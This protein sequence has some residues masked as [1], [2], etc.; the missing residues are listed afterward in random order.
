MLKALLL[1]CTYRYP[2]LRENNIS[3]W[4]ETTVTGHLLSSQVACLNHLF[5]IK[6][7]ENTVLSVADVITGEIFSKVL[8]INC[9]GDRQYV[10]F[11]VVSKADHLNEGKLTRG[12][13]LYIYRRPDFGRKTKWR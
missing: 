11:E 6:N 9:N 12:I 1:V 8:P 5:A 7:D 3:W 10:D 13:N 2:Q 4:G